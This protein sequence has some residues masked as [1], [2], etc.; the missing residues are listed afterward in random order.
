MTACLLLRMNEL[1]TVD[2]KKPLPKQSLKRPLHF[3]FNPKQYPPKKQILEEKPQFA[4]TLFGFS[5]EVERDLRGLLF[6]C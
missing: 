4:S 3:A 2:P 5:K 6:L 1:R